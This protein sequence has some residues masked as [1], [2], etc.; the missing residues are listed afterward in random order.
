MN[1][2]KRH[3]DG[4]VTFA[5]VIFLKNLLNGN[6]FLESSWNLFGVN[7]CS[8]LFFFNDMGLRVFQ[9]HLLEL[10]N[11]ILCIVMHGQKAIEIC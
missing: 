4:T 1:F 5:L 8:L 9:Y 7:V 10:C 3:D 2:I 6:S 11:V